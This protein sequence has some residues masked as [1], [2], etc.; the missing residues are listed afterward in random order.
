VP[1]AST[2]RRQNA[3]PAQVGKLIL[4]QY[5]NFGFARSYGKFVKPSLRVGLG[6][7][8]RDSIEPVWR[9]IIILCG[10]LSLRAI[11]LSRERKVAATVPSAFEIGRHTFIDTGPPFDFYEIMLVRSAPAGTSVEKFTLTPT[12]RR[13]LSPARV[14]VQSA[15][16][17]LSIGDLLGS[18]N[19][20]AIPE[21]SLQREL[22][23][24]RKGLVFSGADVVMQVECGSQTR[25]IR[26]DILDRDIFDAAPKTPKYASR[27]M[28][29]LDELNKPLGAGVLDKPIFPELAK[30][31]PRPHQIVDPQALL[32]VRTGKYD[33]LFEGAPDKPSELCREAEKPPPLA[34]SVRLVS[35]QPF[36]PTFSELPK[37]PQL[38]RMAQIEGLVSAELNIDAD[39]NV[40]KFAFESGH[41]LLRPAVAD[42]VSR[43][44]FPRSAS[45]WQIHLNIEFALNCH[46]PSNKD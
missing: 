15:S 35:C 41:P 40:A 12:G 16:L 32:D 44:K 29:L 46:E 33:S 28:Q 45:S 37:Y 1:A 19:P 34:P 13:C 36:Q 8:D 43:W 14:E 39:G 21:K 10:I 30:V 31:E 17:N 22:R 3:G 25:L 23:Q 27:T 38:A 18:L 2:P 42:A 6:F 9:T 4:E 5:A 11:G 24:R 7:A 26:S 20:C